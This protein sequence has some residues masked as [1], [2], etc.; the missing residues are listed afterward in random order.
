MLQL[1]Y[2][3]YH[4]TNQNRMKKAVI[5]SFKEQVTEANFEEYS[6]ELKEL[7]V[8]KYDTYIFYIRKE[9]DLYPFSLKLMIAFTNTY[10][11]KTGLLIK[12]SSGKLYTSL[13]L[14]TIFVVNSDIKT[15]IIQLERAGGK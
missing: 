13:K 5:I 10:T 3:D 9:K 4:M 7:L 2:R 8:K 15:I 6:R 1:L 12:N 14:E 11:G